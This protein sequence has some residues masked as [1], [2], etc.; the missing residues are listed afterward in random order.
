[1][2]N[3]ARGEPVPLT[4]QLLVDMLDRASKAS[5]ELPESRATKPARF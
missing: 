2:L 4:A 5:F 3:T 1:M